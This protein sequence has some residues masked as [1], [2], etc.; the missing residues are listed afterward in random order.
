[1]FGIDPVLLVLPEIHDSF[2]CQRR[3]ISGHL[4]EQNLSGCERLNHNRAV[5]NLRGSRKRMKLG[6]RAALQHN[7][8]VVQTLEYY[9]WLFAILQRKVAI[10]GMDELQQLSERIA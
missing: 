8:L 5:I 1:M 9:Y 4:P 7:G 2:C 10:Q 3:W 6:G